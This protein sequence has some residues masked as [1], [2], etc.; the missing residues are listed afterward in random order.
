MEAVSK[1]VSALTYQNAY[2]LEKQGR[3]EEALAQYE[4]LLKKSPA[5]LGI[6]SR[7][8]IVS[9]KLK[10]YRREIT[11]IDKAISIHENKYTRLKSTDAK[12]ASLSKKI[13]VLL[14]HTSKR[15]QN[16]MTI[17]EVVKLKKRKEVALKRMK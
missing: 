8:M 6:L 3:P 15:G 4:K 10:D 12:V 1:N 9:R 5:D 17:P 14:G 13:N 7:L 2:S 11:F 16:L